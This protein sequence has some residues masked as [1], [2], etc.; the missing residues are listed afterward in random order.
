[1]C[2]A[3]RNYLVMNAL[4]DKSVYSVYNYAMDSRQIMKRL[5]KSGWELARVKGSHYTF[6]HPDKDNIVTI[7][8]PRKD[9]P[10][11]TL[12]SIYKQA[13]WK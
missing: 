10:K 8:H 9:F 13:G 6:T 4:F 5:E 7:P 2:H 11:G 12:R 3:L 1:M